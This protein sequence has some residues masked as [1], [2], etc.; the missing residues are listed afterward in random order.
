MSVYTA[1]NFKSNYGS[2]TGPF[3]N[4]LAASV[5]G[6]TFQQF[7][8]DLA[9]SVMFYD[10]F[11]NT[12]VVSFDSWEWFGTDVHGFSS[13]YSGA[14]AGNTTST[15][16]IDGTS[17]AQGVMSL[18]TGT[19]ATGYV[20]FTRGYIVTTTSALTLSFRNAVEAVSTGAQTY[21]ARAGFGDTVGSGE[22]A[23]G[24]FFR[25]THSVNSGKWQC[26]TRAAGV[27]TATD[28]G[29]TADTSFHVFAIKVNQAGTS[30][31][32]YVDGVLKQTH[33]T[34]IPAVGALMYQHW[35]IEKSIGTTS[36]GFDQDW[37]SLL[38]SRSS[39]R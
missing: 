21:T 30:V 22:H 17:H 33:T 20:S 12:D 9:D 29:L 4:T 34:D 11:F 25:Y 5:T 13:S 24:I 10:T 37:F 6:L 16:G 31:G 2:A 27:E 18:Q 3:N 26:V 15:Y 1:S 39:A 36:I 38:L 14:G 8:T 23:N 35:K 7:A 19:T 28:S 32:F